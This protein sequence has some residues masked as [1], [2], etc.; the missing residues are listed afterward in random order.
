MGEETLSRI[1]GW[2]E[3][4]DDLE[5][6]ESTITVAGH[7]PLVL[8]VEVGDDSVTLNHVHTE[9]E[10]PLGFADLAV[11][12]LTQRG[13]MV[14]G[15]VVTG[16]E[17]TVV[18][19]R[20]PIYLEGLNRQSFLVAIREITG[21]VDGLNRLISS[22]EPHSEKVAAP[23]SSTGP[24]PPPSQDEP[25][26][27]A[28]V[29]AAPWAPTHQ[30][31]ATGMAAWSDPDPS[32][33]PVTTLGGGVQL[34][35]DEQRGAW[36]SV[37]G[38]NGW[39]GWVDAR[40]LPPIGTAS[41][42]PAAAATTW[43]ARAARDRVTNP[44]AA[45]GSAAHG[46]IEILGVVGAVAIVVGIFLEWGFGNAFDWPATS[47]WPIYEVATWA[48]PTVGL[49]LVIAAGLVLIAALVPT[50]PSA[51]GVAAALVGI[52]LPTGIAV[53]IGI[54]WGWDLLLDI[55]FLGLGV[56]LAGGIIAAAAAPRAR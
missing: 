8:T 3:A 48:Q 13:S 44:W 33:P 39:T 16:T 50:V 19:V 15:E 52:L 2:C 47:A 34:R 31:P 41:P 18:H 28:P 24:T 56:A 35:V 1:A 29:A 9:S 53:S 38:S 27:A 25:E 23:E 32:R 12:S 43:S 21:T 4:E 10:P 51:L 45:A 40:I 54:N 17:S 5:I 26:P 14:A 20:Y 55:D 30:V 46:G 42:T 37:T 49:L 6:E 11:E 7:V 22:A 36:A